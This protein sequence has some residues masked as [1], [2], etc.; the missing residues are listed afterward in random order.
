[1]YVYCGECKK[2]LGEIKNGA[3]YIQCNRCKTVTE[4]GGEEIGRTK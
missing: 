4:I 2:K 3:L 1:M